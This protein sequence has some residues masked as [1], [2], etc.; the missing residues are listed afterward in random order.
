M[1]IVMACPA[2]IRH[3]EPTPYSMII[4]H[5]DNL[6]CSALMITKTSHCLFWLHSGTGSLDASCCT[7]VRGLHMQGAINGAE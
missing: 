2:C 5:D 3:A 6:I 4:R 1:M 7:P